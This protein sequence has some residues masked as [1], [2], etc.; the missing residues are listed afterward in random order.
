[1]EAVIR[2]YTGKGA[3]ELMN[4]LEEHSEDVKAAI[5]KVKGLVSYN[6]A[7]TNDG[8]FSVTVC[9][10]KSGIDESVRIARE[11]V[12]EYGFNIDVTEPQ[13]TNGNVLVG[14]Q[15]PPPAF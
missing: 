13:V 15:S 1:M 9:Q 12:S 6:L 3:T 4:L 11:W 10:D 5:G 8:G 2:T 14:I 7:R